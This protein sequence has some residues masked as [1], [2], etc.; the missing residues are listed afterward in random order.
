METL[1]RSWF[2]NDKKGLRDLD[3]GNYTLK[4]GEF[5]LIL[6]QVWEKVLNQDANIFF[7]REAP[8]A[9]S[10]RPASPASPAPPVIEPGTPHTT[11][12]KKYKTRI[13]YTVKFFRRSRHHDS[14]DSESDSDTDKAFDEPVGF[15]VEDLLKK[16]LPA[17]EEMQEVIAPRTAS[18]RRKGEKD[19]KKIKLRPY[20]RLGKTRLKINSPFLLNVV[21]SVITYS[22]ETPEDHKEGLTRGIFEHPYSDLYL[23]L[24][25]IQGYRSPTN[26][27]RKHHSSSFNAKF[28]EHMDL[29]SQ[30]LEGKRGV[31]IETAKS[32]WA[33]PKP[34]TSFALLW[35]L[36]KPGSDVY[37]RENNGSL[38]AYV[39]DWVKGGATVK[40]GRKTNSPYHVKLWHLVLGTSII[41]PWCRTITI[42]IFDNDREISS[43]PVLPVRFLDDVDGGATRKRLIERG[44]KYFKYSKRPAFL[45]YSGNGLKAGKSVSPHL[46]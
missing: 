43:L 16:D 46:L 20:D 39:V 15:E 21:R 29:L 23:N 31:S 22:S 8:S 7:S 30:Y 41:E 26:D 34:A 42:D 37:V 32:M 27:L 5:D 44:Q 6:P 36:F 13:E 12:E 19:G 40:D 11:V 45:Q 2:E 18:P 25:A 38:N 33:R 9:P 35:L 28:D 1:L 4:S 17:L 10:T 3:R 14:Y 24:E